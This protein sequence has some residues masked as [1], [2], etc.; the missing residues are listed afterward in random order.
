MG[1]KRYLRVGWQG[2]EIKRIVIGGAGR[3]WWKE[4]NM[5]KMN[6]MEFS[7]NQQKYHL[8]KEMML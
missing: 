5:F 7:K 2:M 4:I 6:C 3:G 1:E 8:K